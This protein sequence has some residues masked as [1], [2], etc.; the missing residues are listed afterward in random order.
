MYYTYLR[1]IWTK[2]LLLSRNEPWVTSKRASVIRNGLLV[3]DMRYKQARELDLLLNIFYWI[4]SM[5]HFFF[6]FKFSFSFSFSSL[7]SPPLWVFHKLHDMHGSQSE[8]GDPLSVF[9]LE[10]RW[11]LPYLQQLD[12]PGTS[13]INHTKYETHDNQENTCIVA[14]KFTT[15]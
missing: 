7:S 4:F 11:L 13:C 5:I 6:S 2:D 15:A 12:M 3:R 10:T 1:K 9:Y 8:H 14:S